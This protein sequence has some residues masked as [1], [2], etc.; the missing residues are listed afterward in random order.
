MSCQLRLPVRPPLSLQRFRC[1]LLYKGCFV[2]VLKRSI[3]SEGLDFHASYFVFC[4]V[5]PLDILFS[6]VFF[7]FELFF[8][9]ISYCY[10]SN[11]VQNPFFLKVL[12][13]ALCGI[14]DDL[15]L[16][17]FGSFGLLGLHSVTL[18]TIGLLLSPAIVSNTRMRSGQNDILLPRFLGRQFPGPP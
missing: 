1:F 5:L 8:T 11:T 14:S 12:S 7:F 17:G 9:W 3:V 10:K 18:E 13:S 15:R 4:P 6:S 2:S 16:W